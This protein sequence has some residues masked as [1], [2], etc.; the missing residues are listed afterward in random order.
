GRIMN[1]WLY[2]RCRKQCEKHRDTETRRHKGAQ[3]KNHGCAP[4]CLRV[5]VSLCFLLIRRTGMRFRY[6]LILIASALLPTF[7]QTPKSNLGGDWPM[8]NRDVAGTRHSPLTQI[9]TSNVA[10]LKL[11]WSY[12][13]S[14]APAG[15]GAA[16]APPS[17]E[18]GD[19]Q[20]GRGGRG[21]GRGTAP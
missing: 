3:T 10:N 11:A 13:L 20:A 1:H 19:T 2:S 6:A 8:Y 17:E 12:R 21:G 4:L 15:R 9:S 14:N 18:T 7:A 16:P 5:S